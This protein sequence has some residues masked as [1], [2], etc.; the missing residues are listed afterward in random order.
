MIDQVN[1]TAQRTIHTVN[2]TMI[3]KVIMKRGYTLSVQKNE[4]V[5]LANNIEDC[6]KWAVQFNS[7]LARKKY[8]TFHN[9]ITDLMMRG[10]PVYMLSV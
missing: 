10:G 6:N 4:T 2:F 1:V 8:G 5:L 3:S 9:D 7:R